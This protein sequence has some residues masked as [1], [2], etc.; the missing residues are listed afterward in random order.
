M[1]LLGLRQAPGSLS[2]S[3]GQLGPWPEERLALHMRV[4]GTWRSHGA[5]ATAAKVGPNLEDDQLALEDGE[6]V[7]R[8]TV[9]GHTLLHQGSTEQ[10]VQLLSVAVQG[11]YLVCGGLA[12][13]QTGLVE[14]WSDS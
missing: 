13:L 3:G 14:A 11:L 2:G 1:E 5:V 4:T 8:L 7:G 12:A 6:E 10:E 9:H